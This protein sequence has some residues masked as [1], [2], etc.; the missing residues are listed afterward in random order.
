MTSKLTVTD[1]FGDDSF[2]HPLNKINGLQRCHQ[3][4]THMT[5]SV[6][7]LGKSTTYE[8]TKNG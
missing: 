2:C 3:P 1:F 7:Y 4:M 5:K 6:T 8:V